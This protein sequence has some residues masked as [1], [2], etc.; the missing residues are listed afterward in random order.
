MNKSTEIQSEFN[1]EQLKKLKHFILGSLDETNL[2]FIILVPQYESIENI[3]M[4]CSSIFFQT[5]KLPYF[6]SSQITI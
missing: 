2:D 1:A 3:E 5:T 6:V 4:Y